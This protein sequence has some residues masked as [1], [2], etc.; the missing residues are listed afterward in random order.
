[1]KGLLQK[2]VVP[3]MQ[4]YEAVHP[5]T[6]ILPGSVNGRPPAAGS[7]L[8]GT[9]FWSAGARSTGWRFAASSAGKAAGAAAS[10]AAAGA[11]AASAARAR[12]RAGSP[13]ARAGH[14]GKAVFESF[15]APP[16]TAVA[17]CRRIGAS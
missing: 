7:Q 12:S 10:V 3:W 9:G 14:Q 17:P 6:G 2:A 5:C 13:R 16:G 4:K 8:G 11:A 1:M 15:R